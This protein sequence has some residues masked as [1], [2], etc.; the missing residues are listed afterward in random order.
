M[1]SG[2]AY[3]IGH[4]YVDGEYMCDSIEDVDRGLTQ[5]MPLSEIKKIKVK[6]KTAIP[7]GKYRVRMDRRSPKFSTKPYYWK[8]CRGKVPYLADVPGFAGILIHRGVNQNSSAGCIIV[9]L[10]TKVGMVTNSQSCFEKLYN[11][12]KTA[13]DTI[14]IEIIKS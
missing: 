1:K 12:L 8:F 9:G 7:R 3:Q 2:K 11:K 14:Y 4:I 5:D 13:V 10:N 6:H